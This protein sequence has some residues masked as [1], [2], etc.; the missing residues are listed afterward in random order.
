MRLIY[1]R[2]LVIS[3]LALA[4]TAEAATRPR[5]GGVLRVETHAS[6]SSLDPLQDMPSADAGVRDSIVPLIFDTLIRVDANGKLVPHLAARWQVDPTSTRWQFWFQRGVV[7]QNGSTLTPAIIAQSLSA[8]L[9]G[10]SVRVVGDSVAIESS[11]S[12]PG[13]L[14]ELSLPRNA[15]V[16]RSNGTL[17]GSGPFRVAE[18]QAGR[19]LLL[20][21]NED[22]WN[23]RPYIDTLDITLGQSLR[24]Q[25]MH[26]QLGRADVVELAPDQVRR[27]QQD[28]RRV[29][30]SAASELI[31]IVVPRGTGAAEN[32][33][34]RQALSLAI[35]R[36]TIQNVLLQRQGDPAASL[37]PQWMTGYAFL[38]STTVDVARSRQL[39]TEAGGTQPIQLTYDGSDAIARAVAERVAVNARD[40][41]IV[42]QTI[43]N[44]A[45]VTQ[46]APTLVRMPLDSSSAQAALAGI[47][48][49]IDPAQL[50]RVLAATSTE[51]LYQIERELLGNFRLIPIA[52][53]SQSF[54]VSPRVHDWIM[55]REGLLPLDNVWVEAGQ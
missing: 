16:V 53:A 21:A 55:N 8:S 18:F 44:G 39:R 22:Y 50:P 43:S 7:M 45:T 14:A 51:E 17:T 20:K 34:L 10:F 37:L 3:S 49:E 32:Q 35:D 36:G 38:F 33:T 19:E 12:V 54:A 42:V 25:A 26:F 40:A 5:Y 28:N 1:L 41:G 23:G 31:A 46:G 11:S 9:T 52:H 6:I 29:I 2:W 27:T 48:G 47:V 4:I 15:I 13:M 24:D 30:S